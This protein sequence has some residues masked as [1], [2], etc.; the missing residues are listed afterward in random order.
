[1]C[2]L[3]VY[4]YYAQHE[5]EQYDLEEEKKTI[6]CCI[7]LDIDECYNGL[8][9][10]FEILQSCDDKMLVLCQNLLV[11]RKGGIGENETL[12]E[13]INKSE[14]EKL[15]PFRDADHFCGKECLNPKTKCTKRRILTS[16]Q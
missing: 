2:E 8:R 14:D 5:H 1:M 9:E 4:V 3:P 12:I 11:V 6:L 10:S 15:Q 16:G 7:G 13:V